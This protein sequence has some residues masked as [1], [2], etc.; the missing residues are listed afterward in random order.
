MIFNREVSIMLRFK[1]IKPIIDNNEIFIKLH[2]LS[3]ENFS[4]FPCIIDEYAN[5][6][7]EKIELSYE[8]NMFIYHVYIKVRPE[9][10][11]RFFEQVHLSDFNDIMNYNTDNIIY[12]FLDDGK[13]PEV[14]EKTFIDFNNYDIINISPKIINN[15]ITVYINIKKKTEYV[16]VHVIRN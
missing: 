14:L 10:P 1:Q 15:N 3:V 7:V 2:M 8:N 11:M 13:A 9:H 6:I 12:I 5:Y 4:Y 16:A